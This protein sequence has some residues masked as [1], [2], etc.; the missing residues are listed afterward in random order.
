M[1]TEKYSLL[2]KGVNIFLPFTISRKYKPVFIHTLVFSCFI[3][4]IMG[5]QIFLQK[6]IHDMTSEVLQVLK[7]AFT[8]TSKI[9]KR[10]WLSEDSNYNRVFICLLELRYL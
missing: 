10:T 2:I 3:I 7:F 8:S 5:M 1:P 6:T 4:L 9:E